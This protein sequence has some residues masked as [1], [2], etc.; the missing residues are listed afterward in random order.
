MNPSAEV[1][2][3][4]PQSWVEVPKNWVDSLD[5]FGLYLVKKAS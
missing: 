3:P 5:P 1:A 2:I 4:L